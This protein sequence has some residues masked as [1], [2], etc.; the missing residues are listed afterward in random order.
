MDILRAL[1][2]RQKNLS[3]KADVARALR[4]SSLFYSLPVPLLYILCILPLVE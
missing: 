2:Q 1:S 4:P 3:Q